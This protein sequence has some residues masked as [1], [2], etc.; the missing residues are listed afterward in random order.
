MKK[1]FPLLL[2][3][4]LFG[5]CAGGQGTAKSPN[6]NY[7]RECVRNYT[8]EGSFFAGYSHKSHAFVKG[9][10]QSDAIKR[11]ARY[12]LSDGWQIQST[13]EKLGIISASQGVSFG[14]GERVPL[15]VGIEQINGGVNIT[16]AF[17]T[18]GGQVASDENIQS[19]FCSVVQAVQGK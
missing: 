8:S 14:K 17:S 19:V 6:P 15:N 2:T 18:S 13:D 3:V 7:L 4:I 5:G 11:A 10:S 12:I 1:L 9:V 16:F